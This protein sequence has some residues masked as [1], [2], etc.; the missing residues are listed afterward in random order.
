MEKT[1]KIPNLVKM[2]DLEIGEIKE[3]LYGDEKSNEIGVC[4]KVNQMYR[5]WIISTVILKYV[6][7]IISAIIILLLSIII[8]KIFGA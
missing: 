2:H 4:K 5:S 3:T 6:F 7:P 1:I 8:N